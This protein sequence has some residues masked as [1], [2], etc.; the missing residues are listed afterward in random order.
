MKS[1]SATTLKGMTKTVIVDAEAFI[2]GPSV[3]LVSY[4]IVG[5]PPAPRGVDSLTPM[6]LQ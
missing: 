4:A 2:D 5:L 1:S 6:G 3:A